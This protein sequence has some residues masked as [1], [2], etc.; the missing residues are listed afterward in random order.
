MKYVCTLIV[1]DDIK[2]S[3]KF[4]EDILN[5]QIKYD[6][7][8]NV[9]FESGFAIHLKSHYQGLIDSDMPH[10]IL[11][12]SHNMELYFELDELENFCDLLTSNS[13]ELVHSLREQPWGQ[14]VIRFYDPDFHIIEVG[15]TME[16]L[17][18]RLKLSGLSVEDIAL[19]TS[20]PLSFIDMVLIS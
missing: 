14:R 12:K 4:Y 15:E 5:Q 10:P 9:T 1:V 19:K 13:I 17:I 7:G 2:R 18:R 6:F 16:A 11:S 8:E 20:L 3:R